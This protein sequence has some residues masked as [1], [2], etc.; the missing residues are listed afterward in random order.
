MISKTQFV[1]PLV[2]DYISMNTK[3]EI[4]FIN[5]CP[6]DHCYYRDMIKFTTGKNK[7]GNDCPEPCNRWRV[8][9][10]SKANV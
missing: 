3:F 5:E 9:A 4:D 10:T 1:P 2:R 8:Y 7:K 6:C